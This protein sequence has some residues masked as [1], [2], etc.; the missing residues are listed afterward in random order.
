MQRVR[1][2]QRRVTGLRSKIEELFEGR[3]VGEGLLIGEARI[4]GEVIH[5]TKLR[6][7]RGRVRKPFVELEGNDVRFIYP[8]KGGE[9]FERLYYPLLGFLGRI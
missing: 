8:L 4:K 1:R 9:S 5:V 7:T 6:F 3:A 2:R